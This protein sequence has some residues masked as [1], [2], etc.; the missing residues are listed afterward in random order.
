MVIDLLKH[1]KSFPE[2]QITR[3]FVVHGIQVEDVPRAWERHAYNILSTCDGFKTDA[4]EIY[5]MLLQ[6]HCQL[7]H[8]YPGTWAVTKFITDEDGKHFFVWYLANDKVNHTPFIPFARQLMYL[9]ETWGTTE[10]C[11]SIS[12]YGKLDWAKIFPEYEVYCKFT[13]EL[14]HGKKERPESLIND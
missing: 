4:D 7:L 8:S 11:N 12:F 9:L 1:Q 6:G 13:K 5:S 3:E 2:G 10:G 14:P